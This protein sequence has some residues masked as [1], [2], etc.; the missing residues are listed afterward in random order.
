MKQVL[1]DLRSGAV[2]VHDVPEPTPEH[3]LRARGGRAFADQLRDGARSCVA[4]LEV[5]APEGACS[6]RPRPQDDRRRACRRGWRCSRQGTQPPRSAQRIRVQPRRARAR[7]GWG[8]QVRARATASRASAP[9]HASHAEV[10]SVPANLVVPLPREVATVDAAFA[11][12]AAIALHAL[13]LAGVGPGATVVVV[14][15]G[16]IGQLAGR[17]IEASGGIAVGTDPREDRVARFGA[18]ADAEGVA[19]L[20]NAAS[21]G[22]GAD[23]VLVCAATA[24]SEPVAL[25]TELARDRARIVVV[26]DVGLELDRRALYEKELELVVARSYGPG[27]YERDYEERGVD[28]PAGYVRWTEGRNVEAVVDLL[29]RGS[30]SVG[31][32]VTHRFSIAEGERAYATLDE[33][34]ALGIVIEYPGAGEQRERTIRLGPATKTDALRVGLVG[35]GAFMRGTLVPALREQERRVRRGLCAVRR[36]RGFAR[37]A[38][39]RAGRGNRRRRAG[40]VAGSRR[41]RHRDASQQSCVDHSGRARAGEKRLGREAVGGVLGAAWRGRRPDALGTRAGRAQPP[42]RAACPDPQGG[43]S[44]PGDDPHSCRCRAARAGTLARRPRGGGPCARRDLP[45]RRPRLVPRRRSADHRF[46]CART[47]SGRHRVACRATALRGRIRC[48]DRLRRRRVE[49]ASKE[50]IEVLG[51]D[52][53]AVLDD[54]QRLELYGTRETTVKSR[55]DKGH[56][57]AVAAF[58]SAASGAARAAGVSRGAVARRGSVARAT[59]LRSQWRARRGAPPVL[60]RIVC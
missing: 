4:R 36:E 51:Q 40:P 12:P 26:G 42:F 53:A 60:S 6:A 20:V 24:S 22:R 44:R 31:D 1:Q 39:R 15:L 7:D 46:R 59:R 16:L 27:R 37:R 56:A 2:S 55:R 28:Y 30:L 29:A 8:R 34:D 35:A 49:W 25:A 23:A 3:R 11:A 43:G 41:D 38:A 32:L 19:A 5:V 58:V 9:G 21:R 48:D 17:L 50:R 45:L 10:V 47:E 33:P 54:F 52:G 18:G 57:A 13:R 14:G